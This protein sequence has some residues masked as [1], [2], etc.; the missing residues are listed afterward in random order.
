MIQSLYIDLSKEDEIVWMPANNGAFS[1]KSTYNMLTKSQCQIQVNGNIIMPA[2][3]K[4]LWRCNTAHRIKLFAWNCI[5]DLNSTRFKLSYYDTSID[6]NCGVCEQQEE[7]ME[8][9]I[10]VC[11]RA[12]A[13][14]R[15]VQVDMD[16]VRRNFSTVS[17]WGVS[18][19]PTASVH[20]I[21]YH[22]A[23]HL[24]SSGMSTALLQDNC[25]SLWIP[26]DI[27]ILKFNVDASFDP[28]TN[29]LGT[30]IVLR[31]HTGDCKCIRGEYANGVPN[32]E[33]RECMTIREA[34]SWAKRLQCSMI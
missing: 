10:F 3:W 16:D 7:T 4:N 20:K 17:E 25:I 6:V 13:V 19:K 14:W 24:H 18:L 12:K 21:N 33:M 27:G 31:D 2:V 11:P 9:L 29:Q 15:G 34:L 26:P 8:H 28:D 1:V 30:G 23:S 32:A 22:L 5:R